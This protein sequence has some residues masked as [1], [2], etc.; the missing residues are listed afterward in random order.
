MREMIFKGV[1]RIRRRGVL[2]ILKKSMNGHFSLYHW[3]NFLDQNN[4]LLMLVFI[5][6]LVVSLTVLKTTN[7]N[8][9]TLSRLP[10]FYILG[11]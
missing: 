9:S 6:S 8:Q 7:V 1:A 5:L 11:S 10:I 2:S 4:W 3:Y